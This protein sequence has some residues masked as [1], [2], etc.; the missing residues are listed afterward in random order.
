MI[1]GSINV[2]D[3]K[4]ITSVEVSRGFALPTVLIASVVMLMV[5]LSGLSAASSANAAL[6]T[7]YENKIMSQAADAGM[8]LVIG[9]LKQTGGPAS[10]PILYPNSS[11]TTTVNTNLCPTTGA[12]A[13]CFLVDEPTRKTTF[14]VSSAAAAA[15]GSR[16]LTVR[17][18]LRKITPSGAVTREESLDKILSIRSDNAVFMVRSDGPPIPMSNIAFLFLR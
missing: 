5:L 12:P 8:A 18:I 9:C 6:R 11:C 7:Q 2:I 10:W 1:N 17:G 3:M 13:A 15:D 14:T 16:R 4:R